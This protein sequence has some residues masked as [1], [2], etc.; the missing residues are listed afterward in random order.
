MTLE[1]L[2][3][4]WAARWVVR[5][6]RRVERRVQAIEQRSALCARDAMH[7]IDRCAGGVAVALPPLPPP[8]GAHSALAARIRR[9]LLEVWECCLVLRGCESEDK[10]VQGYRYGGGS[11]TPGGAAECCSW[12]G[13]VA[14]IWHS[15]SGWIDGGCIHYGTACMQ[16]KSSTHELQVPWAVAA[17]LQSACGTR[18]EATARLFP[19]RDVNAEQRLVRI[20]AH[21]FHAQGAGSQPH[22]HKACGRHSGRASRPLQHGAA[23]FGGWPR[24]MGRGGHPA[25]PPFTAA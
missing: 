2:R 19:Q 20:S 24:P 8:R 21:V 17:L 11:Q 14:N 22:R 7:A 9:A 10:V 6:G 1:V 16:L 25:H 15:K 12:K 23:V 3:P 13:T 4:A 5:R 18:G